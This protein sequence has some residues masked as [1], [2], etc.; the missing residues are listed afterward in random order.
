VPELVSVGEGASIGNVVML[1]NARVAGGMLHLARI[2]IGANAC[3]GS[4]VTV[5]GRTR[6]G[7]HA[8]LEGKS[9][10]REGQDIPPRKSPSSCWAGWPLRCCSSCRCFPPS[11]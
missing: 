8:H 3:L 9:S 4:Y 10:L 11:C 2:D 7:E 6:I 5:E 1:E